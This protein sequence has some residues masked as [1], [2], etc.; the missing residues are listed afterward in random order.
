MDGWSRWVKLQV[1]DAPGMPIAIGAIGF[2]VFGLCLSLFVRP[3]RVWVR[4]RNTSAGSG[5]GGTGGTGDSGSGGTG[6]RVV[7][8]GGL[9]R[10]DARAGLAEDVTE[11]A[12]RLVGE[13]VRSPG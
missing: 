9:D 13:P 4:V 8:V 1:G 2:A 12:D 5:S 11:L 7:E 3:R 6:S 10:A